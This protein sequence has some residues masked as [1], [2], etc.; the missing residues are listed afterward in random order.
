[1]ERYLRVPVSIITAAMLCWP[2]GSLAIAAENNEALTRQLQEIFHTHPELILDVLRGNS[3]AVLDIAQQGANARRK[4][5]L[6]RQWKQDAT[7]EK[8]MKLEN[9]PMRGPLNARVRIV[10]FSDFTCSFCQQAA[11]TV[12]SI[13]KE[14]GDSVSLVFKNLPL[15]EGAG[16]TAAQYFVAL[17][18]QSE[19]GAWSFYKELFQNRDRLVSEGEAYIKSVVDTLKIDKRRLEKDRRGKKVAEILREDQEDAQ[20]L[21]IDG[22][23]CFVVNN[24]M[25][26]GA[27]PL[28]LFKYA[29]DTARALPLKK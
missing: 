14:Y 17:S 4:G 22:T 28:D 3:E 20:K 23:P 24:L 19:E 7:V 18:L 21:G 25:V 1:M 16:V 15:S 5:A 2:H 10:A 13:L 8:K 26:R 9:R 29:V 6:E 11:V 27:L 12:E